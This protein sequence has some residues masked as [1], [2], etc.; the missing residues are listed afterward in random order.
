MSKLRL[1]PRSWAVLAGIVALLAALAWASAPSTPPNPPLAS[2]LPQGALMT[3][4]SEDFSALV[5][6]WNA[7][8]EQRAWLG[9]ADYSAFANS[10]L[11]TRLAD[12]QGVFADAAKSSL[13]G[14]FMKE[15]AGKESIFAWYDIGNLEFLYISHLPQERLS[16]LSL[17]TKRGSFARREAGG[18]TFYIRTSSGSPATADAASPA[19]SDDLSDPQQGAGS[20]GTDQPRTVAFAVRGEWLLLA[21]REDLLAGALQL[22]SAAQRAASPSESQATTGWYAA[23]STAGP[24]QHGDLHMLLDL[25]SLTKTPQFR[26]YWIQRNVTATRRYRAAVVDLYREPGQFREERVLLPMQPEDASA[27]Q[28]G[29]GLL[30][31]MVPERAGVYRAVAHPDMAAVLKAIRDKVLVREPSTPGESNTSPST[32]IAV[33]PAGD[34]TDF[35]TRIDAPDHK[36]EAAKDSFAELRGT[37]EAA[38]VDSMLSVD[39]TDPPDPAHPFVTIHS[40]VVLHAVSAWNRE[41]FGSAMLAG[42][43]PRLTTASLGVGWNDVAA[44]DGNYRTLGAPAPLCLAIEGPLAILT[45]DPA[46]M[47][48]ILQHNIA[49]PSSPGTARV[50]AGFRHDQERA[51]FRRLEAELNF[52]PNENAAS[53]EAPG[54]SL[55]GAAPVDLFRDNLPSLSDTFQAMTSEHFEETSDG[56]SVHQTVLYHWAQPSASR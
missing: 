49:A 17:M 16:Q 38:G 11:F 46:L 33:A 23:A 15:I 43:R 13:D 12:A 42:V 28:P 24:A 56:H 29:L 2:M 26:T 27:G 32:G 53:I 40:A 4:E 52:T 3:V 30:E 34:A 45:T 35:D 8:P 37:L 1:R 39:R 18:T 9:S 48:D 31:Q 14:N 47:K 44:T 21:T 51:D 36:E 25:Q 7:S 19:D 54:S 41:A 22:M 20:E 50:V 6:A 10:R 55:S 5:A